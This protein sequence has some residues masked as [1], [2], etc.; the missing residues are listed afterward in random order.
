LRREVGPRPPYAA[1]VVVGSVER[2][3]LQAAQSCLPQELSAL[4]RLICLDRYERQALAARRR[5][6]RALAQRS[7]SD[8]SNAPH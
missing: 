8:A 2:A 7:Q 5:A 4:R 1:P 3:V 6:F